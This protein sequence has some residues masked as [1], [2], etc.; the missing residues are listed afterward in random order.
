MMLAKSSAETKVIAGL[1]AAVA[2]IVAMTAIQFQ[3]LRSFQEHDRTVAHTNVVLLEITRAVSE[4]QGA[5]SNARY[6]IRSKDSRLLNSYTT[7]RQSA[8][9]HLAALRRLTADNP[10]QQKRLDNLDKLAARRLALVSNLLDASNNEI[11]AHLSSVVEDLGVTSRQMDQITG[12]M[13]RDEEDLLDGREAK[14]NAAAF[15]NAATLLSGGFLSLFL[16]G[17]AGILIRREL[18]A[19]RASEALLLESK[20]RFRMLVES[21]RDDAILLLNPEGII[22][23]SSGGAERIIGYKADEIIGSGFQRLY[24]PADIEQR[25]PERQLGIA[26]HTGKFET[27]AW[28]LRNDGARFLASVVITAIRDP[29]DNLINFAAVMRD[30]T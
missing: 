14:T 15:W 20:E 5:Q 6:Y 26:S 18:A 4:F 28:R 8:L 30:L 24:L 10:R 11:P 22:T 16:V 12:A 21:M 3:A 17:S 7:A 27:E 1:A 2:V 19:R 23:M 29:Q 9:G 25:E 13:Q